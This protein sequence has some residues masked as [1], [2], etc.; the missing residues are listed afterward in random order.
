MGNKTFKIKVIRYE[1]IDAFGAYAT[2]SVKKDEGLVLLNV[3]SNLLAS[4][5]E[6]DISFKEMI[7]STLMHEIGHALEEWFDMEFSEDRLENIIDS[8]YQKQLNE[9]E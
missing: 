4:L 8:Y 7:V 9:E 3:E 6:P 2:T 1:D 5:D